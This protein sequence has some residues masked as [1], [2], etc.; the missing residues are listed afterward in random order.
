MPDKQE[1]T[2][3]IDDAHLRYRNFSG[4]KTQFNPPGARNFCVDLDDE[5]AAA[6]EADGWNVKYT[7]PREEGDAPIPF[8]KVNV[9][10][11]IKP[12]RVVLVTST[13]QVNLTE[14][15]VSILDFADLKK[16]DMIIRPFNYDTGGNTGISGY[17]KTMFATIEEDEL[18]RKY[19]SNNA[20][21]VAE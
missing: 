16:V 13:G 20:T 7:N 18:E 6:L 17:L 4:N 9:K 1:N 2:I 10:Y 12:P 21:D 8:L 15:K 3:R 19:G 5:T 14:D 11:E